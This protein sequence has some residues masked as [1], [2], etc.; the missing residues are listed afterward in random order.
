MRTHE[1]KNI[2][3]LR[4]RHSMACFIIITGQ[5]KITCCKNDLRRIL[6]N[7]YHCGIF[8]FFCV[9]CSNRCV[10][11]IYQRSYLKVSGICN[12]LP[13]KKPLCRVCHLSVRFC[14]FDI[15]VTGHKI[16]NWNIPCLMG[17]TFGLYMAKNCISI[18]E[19]LKMIN[20][21]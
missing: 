1:K 20:C 9:V 14:D 7:K 17:L 11:H 4:L 10:V 2:S 16:L 3:S 18:F 5:L 19:G 13:V 21:N 6:A 15:K 12:V 8:H